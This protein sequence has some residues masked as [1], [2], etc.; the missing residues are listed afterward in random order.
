MTA[1]ACAL[2]GF[3]VWSVLL[4]FVLVGV[5]AGAVRG[6]HALTTF[7][8][9]G[10]DLNDFGRRVTRAH[11]NSL[12]NLAIMTS[13]LLYAIA[14]DQQALTNG[15][16]ALAFGARVVQTVAHMASGSTPAVLVRATAFSVQMVIALVW[17]WRFWSAAMQA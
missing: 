2:L 3:V 11:A 10:T 9:E 6:G 13:L 12:E 14:T 15:L 8:P 5:R 4:T 7:R 16:A 1:T 17:A